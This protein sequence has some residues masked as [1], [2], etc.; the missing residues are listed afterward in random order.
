MFFELEVN[1]DML[2][3]ISKRNVSELCH[4]ITLH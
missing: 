3:N 2:E 1:T 4:V